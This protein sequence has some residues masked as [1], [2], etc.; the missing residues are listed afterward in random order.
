MP[1]MGDAWK[2]DVSSRA[3]FSVIRKKGGGMPL[4][5]TDTIKKRVFLQIRAGE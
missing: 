3:N 1:L 5:L 4:E 2:P